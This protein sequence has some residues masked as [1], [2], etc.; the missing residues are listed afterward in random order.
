MRKLLIASGLAL[1]LAA[2]GGGVGPV[3]APIQN[4]FDQ[5]NAFTRQ[6]CGYTFVFSTIDQIIKALG[7]PPIIETVGG[8]LCTQAKSLALQQAP[9]AGVSSEGPA[10]ILGTVIINGK[11]V[12][13]AVQR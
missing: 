5:I 3:P 11:P 12:T 4:I 1:S 2:C 9:K 13:I 7:G 10:A 6:A 8:L